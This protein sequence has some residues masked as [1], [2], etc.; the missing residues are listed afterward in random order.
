M[1]RRHLTREQQRLVALAQPHADW[2]M[3][4]ATMDR[5]L[6][7]RLFI[8]EHQIDGIIASLERH[9]AA[10]YPSALGDHLPEEVWSSW[11]SLNYL[12]R[13]RDDLK[14]VLSRASRS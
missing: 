11:A 12:L 8:V 4:P 10:P 13:A 14:S 9:S 1:A 2:H 6:T 7:Y 5:Y 3:A